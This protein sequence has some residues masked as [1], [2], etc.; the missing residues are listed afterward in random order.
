MPIRL[1]R[2]LHSWNVTPRLA[3]TIQR[4]LAGRVRAET[5]PRQFRYIAGL[6]AAFANNGAVC[7]AAVVIWDL[8]TGEPVESVL[9]RRAVRFPYVPGLLTFREAPALL[10]ALRRVSRQ[11]DA[12]MCDGHGMAHPRRFGI[13]SHLGVFCGLPS[14][15][16]AKSVLVGSFEPPGPLRGSVSPLLDGDT[17]IGET[18]RTQDGVRPVFVSVGHLMNQKT[19]RELT[20]ACATRF[21]LPEPTRLADRMVARSKG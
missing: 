11:P 7:V 6:D 14:I 1:P 17:V 16:C 12:L 9:A 3:V 5:P 13:A 15:G 8:A 19:A 4:R 21:R 18:V 2:A 20:L 10:A